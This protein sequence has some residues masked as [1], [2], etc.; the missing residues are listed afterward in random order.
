M[1][2]RYQVLTHNKEVQW[3]KGLPILLSAYVISKDMSSGNILLQCKF[4][5]LSKK[6]LT[7][8]S[9]KIKCFTADGTELQGIER[10]DYNSLSAASYKNV[11]E[12]I[13]IILPDQNTYKIEIIPISVMLDDSITWQNEKK[14]PFQEI[15]PLYKSIP[16]YSNVD[17]DSFEYYVEQ[18]NRD[19][20]ANVKPDYAH[21]YLPEF[22]TDYIICGC[23]QFIL[24]DSERCPLCGMNIELLK[25]LQSVDTLMENLEKD[26]EK[27]EELLQEEIT[28][29][30]QKKVKRK[31]QIIISAI[32]AIIIVAAIIGYIFL[33]QPYIT[34]SKALVSMEN[35]EYAT[36]ITLF[37]DLD[38][39]KDSSEQLKETKYLWAKE[40]IKNNDYEYAITLLS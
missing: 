23:G 34:Y 16:E 36:A 35:G 20:A 6:I 8:L 2:D 31:K 28:I 40:S 26:K 37:E 24:P 9:I 29:K 25:S 7:A 22:N 30:V 27:Q 1:S 33:L 10:Y 32:S 14:E 5:N 17:E 38:K 12:N 3:V 19:I 15:V 39:Y 21:Q 18:Y 4:Q 11:G 13:P